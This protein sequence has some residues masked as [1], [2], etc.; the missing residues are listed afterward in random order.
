MNKTYI[1]ILCVFILG[2]LGIKILLPF[3]NVGSNLSTDTNH[4]LTETHTPFITDFSANKLAPFTPTDTLTFESGEKFSIITRQI[5][6][7]VPDRDIPQSVRLTAG[8]SYMLMWALV[9]FA[10]YEFIRFIININRNRIFVENNVKRLRLFGWTML[11]IAV[12][13]IVVG[14]TEEQFISRMDLEYSGRMLRSVWDFPW[15]AL[16][17]G[18]SGLLISRVWAWGIHLREDSELTI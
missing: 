5:F 16:L 15:T 7:F 17:T 9:L 11:L 1:N 10:F 2:L 8:I 12:L 14:L 3:F 6:L 13:E 4:I 18:F